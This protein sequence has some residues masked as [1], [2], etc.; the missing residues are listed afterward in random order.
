MV[1]TG[2]LFPPVE[3][4]DEPGEGFTHKLGDEVRISSPRLGGLVNVVAHAEQAPPWTFGIRALI[5]NLA[6]RGLL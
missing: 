5:A 4:R 6:A 1:F 3:D 2:T